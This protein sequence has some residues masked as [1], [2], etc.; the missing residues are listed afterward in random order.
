MF[1]RAAL[2]TLTANGPCVAMRAPP[3]AATPRREATDAGVPVT[4]AGAA[5]DAGRRSS[6]GAGDSFVEAP[7]AKT[8]NC[9]K[10]PPPRLQR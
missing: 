10:T 6:C 3:A 8:C 1:E 4:T 5:A 7:S 9:E 2:Q